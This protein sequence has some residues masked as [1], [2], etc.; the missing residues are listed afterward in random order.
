M[1]YC[2]VSLP[3]PLDQS[4]TYQLPETLRRRIA[5]G[6]RVL[7][8]FGPRKLTGL[9]VKVHDE[10]PG[11]EMRDVLRLLDEE[12]VL[13]AELLSLGRWIS[14]Y[15][16][17]PLGEV[18]RGMIPLA[19]EVRK[20]RLY[21][22]TDSGRDAARQLLL[23][24]SAADPAVQV[25]TLLEARPLSA[26]YLKK[27]LPNALNVIRSLEKKGFIE[28]EDLEAQR[29]P[30]RASAA[31]LRASWL[32]PSPSD[33]KLTKHERELHAF[34]ELHP[35]TH[36]LEQL[37]TSVKG[38]SQAAR[39]LARRK[40]I[41]LESEAPA[42]V[43]AD[44]AP[45]RTLNTHQLLAY[46]HI[47]AALRGDAFRTFLLEGVTGSGKTEVY[48]KAIDACLAL[49]R[50]A[51]L[52]VPEIALTPAVAGQFFHR[53]GNQVAMLHSAFHDAERAEQWRRIR[54]G[55]AT[56]VVGTRSG[57]FAPVRNLGLVVIDEEHDHSYKQQETPRYNGRDVAIVRAQAANAVVI[58]GS[59]TPSLESR[60]NAEHGKY[61]LLELPER[62]E[63][64]PMPDVEVIDMRQEFLE[65]RK[66]AT[67]SR[68]LV[69]TIAE[70]LERGEQTMLLLNRRG[71]SSF[72][73]CRSCGERLQCVNCAVTLT[74]HRRDRRML[75]H[76]C[77]YA[78]KV[79]SVCPQC[80]SEHLHFIGTG[81]EKVE[82]E[83]HRDFPSA[84]IARMD[85]DTVSGKRHFESILHGFREGD[86]D[87][88]VG[89]QMIAKGHDIPNVTLVGVVSADVGL[90]L[91]DFRAAE[92]TF[93]LLTQA[94]G[95]AGRGDL[96]GIVLIQTI[97]PEHYAI[98]F[99]SEQN[100]AGFYA[101][102]IQFRKLMRYPPFSALANVLVRS[103]KQED[104][105]ARSTEL[106]RLLDPAPEG[107]KVL[108]PAEAPV[109]KL[110]SEFRYQLLLKAAS[111]KR[112][113]ETLRDLQKFAREQ[114]W[115]PTS[116]VIDVDPLTLL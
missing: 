52:L 12:P 91:P 103:Q 1:T 102:E 15:Y 57:V 106:G 74:Y 46:Q 48:L 50:S 26:A 17:A 35:G 21:S 32:A 107:L 73:A 81:S 6:C 54:A 55:L 115:N 44:E 13:G 88:L 18:L 37:E 100:Y 67:F 36:N 95:R 77:N 64:R 83:L 75:C 9:V 79:P 30:L 70:R 82:D 28:V 29:D 90:G 10:A 94:A 4:F 24:A 42:G 22:L 116:L 33:A 59:A 51:L 85:R 49:G 76:Y 27:K 2:D 112:L 92:R 98:R 78:A 93:Q 80:G 86:F 3:V 16:C 60:Y 62:I 111:R 41:A 53:F 101:K 11:G 97:N 39:S 63:R 66:L 34:L 68:R 61:T 87:I 89:T 7:V 19:G 105:L 71:F 43:F 114:K 109:P 47:E 56:V 8:P 45:A 84:R 96:P 5:V 20:T 69:E 38:A 108:G 25:L 110:K 104:A 31:R 65:T 40:L 72:V 23:G 113:N 99:A 14:E 58:L